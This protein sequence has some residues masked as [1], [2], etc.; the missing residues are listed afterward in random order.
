VRDTAGVLAPPPLIFG[1]PLLLAL[2]LERV[3]PMN[4]LAGRSIVL[5]G[6][7]LVAAAV[8]LAVWAISTFRRA[9]TSPKPTAPTTSLVATGPY[10]F[11]RNP[12]YVSL[13][14][15]YVG[16]SLWARA[17]WPL[18]FLPSVLLTIQIGVVDREERYLEAKFGEEYGRFKAR[19]GRW[20]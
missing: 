4:L 8:L 12:M 20:I 11:S 13:T 9:G 3:F 19:V 15:L 1:V 6:R 14:L 2:F 17:A 18:F 7:I 5:A 10:R 16:I